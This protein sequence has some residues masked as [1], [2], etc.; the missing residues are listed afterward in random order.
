MS[1]V[2]QFHA[3][4]HAFNAGEVALF[5]DVDGTLLEIAQRP[6]SVQVSARLRG[7]IEMLAQRNDKAVAFVSGRTLADLDR[8]FAP[9]QLPAAGLHGLE[10]RDVAGRIHRIDRDADLCNLRQHLSEKTYD[11]LFY[12]DKGSAMV[13]HYR[14]RP[15]LQTLAGTVAAAALAH[16]LGDWQVVAGKMSYEIRPVGIDKSDAIHAFLSEAPFAGRRA[17]FFGD[18]VSDEEAFDY[19]NSHAGWS[20]HIGPGVDTRAKAVLADPTDVR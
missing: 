1:L 13:V 10:R 11:G 6:G 18:D 2:P 19:V 15:D 4:K 3:L 8:L 5:L 7:L 20:V 17:A 9:L 14:G 12:E 16:A